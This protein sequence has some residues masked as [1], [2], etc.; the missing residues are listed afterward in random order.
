MKQKLA[1]CC[2]LI[3]TPQ[4]LV[5]DEPTTGV[6]P[7]SRREFWAI[8]RRVAGRGPGAA[9]QHALHGRGRPLRPACVLMHAGQAI[10]HGTPDEVAAAVPASCWRSTGAADARQPWRGC[11]LPLDGRAERAPLRRPPARGPRRRRPGPDESPRRSPAPRRAHARSTRR[12]RGRFVELMA[13]PAARH[14]QHPL[15]GAAS[16]PSELTGLTRRFGDFTAVDATRPGGRGRRDLRLPRRQ[17][18]GQDHGHP[19]ALRPAAAQRGRGRGGWLPRRPRSPN[20]LKRQH[21]LHEPAVQPLRRPARCARTW[22]SSAASTGSRAGASRERTRR[23]AAA[24]RPRP[25]APP[26]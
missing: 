20:E 17:R 21:R 13:R 2:T 12:H 9:G 8:L 23:A 7:V 26:R 5:L 24:P 15:T 22:S 16:S 14:D 18:R 11:G 3:H 6:D 25:G 1:L 4:V 19:H 10:A